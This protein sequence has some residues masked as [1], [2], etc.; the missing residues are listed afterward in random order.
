[1]QFKGN[2]LSKPEHL[3][4]CVHWLTDPDKKF[5]QYIKSIVP[6]W[7]ITSAQYANW[8]NNPHMIRTDWANDVLLPRLGDK[9]IEL[10]LQKWWGK[11]AFVVAQGEGLFTHDRLLKI[12]GI[13]INLHPDEALSNHIRRERDFFEADILDYLRDF[14]GAQK[15]IVDAGANIGNHAVYFANFLKYDS[16]L[17]F[18][19]LPDNFRLL[20]LNLAYPNIELHQLALSDNKATLKMA[21]NKGNM[22][23][24]RIYENGSI[25]IGAITLDSLN[26]QNVT[27]LKIDVE[28]YE[29]LVLEGAKDTISRCHPLILIEDGNSTY[30]NLLPT[31]YVLEKSWP[32]H[33]TYLY[34][35]TGKPYLISIYSYTPGVDIHNKSLPKLGDSVEQ[36]NVELKTYPG[37]LFRWDFIP[38]ELDRERIFIFTDTADVIF[39]KSIPSLSPDYIYVA[40][41]GEIFK[42][43]RFWRSIMR[44]NPQFDTLENET[45]YN[46]GTFACR[47]KIMD[48]WISFL[49][50]SRSKVRMMVTEQLLFNVWLRQPENYILLKELPDL[51]T[52][53]YA[54]MEKGVTIL[55]ENNQFVN[56]NGDLYSVVHFNGS[57]KELLKKIL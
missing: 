3:L 17:C 50:S 33:K 34:K 12:R 22:G 29:P 19:P 40:N 41:E 14:H 15:V 51:F 7:Y 53:I 26:L 49:Q 27:L 38:K 6:G 44:R 32:K 10:S 35:W 48:T 11:T 2:E 8:T 37:H 24:S 13:E 21:P 39:Q 18:E 47:G 9:D 57:T 46:V 1:M 5:P 23:A 43:N 54:N 36:V 20:E 42:N 25:E 52:S 56:K 4:D 28:G 30:A 55:N 45:I 31:N 16:I